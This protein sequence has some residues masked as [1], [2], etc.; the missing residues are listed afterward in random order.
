MPATNH[1]IERL[2]LTFRTETPTPRSLLPGGWWI[3]CLFGIAVGLGLWQVSRWLLAQ[4]F[5]EQLASATTRDEAMMAIES[6]ILLDPTSGKELV[7][8]LRNEDLQ[9]ARTSYRIIEGQITRWQALSATDCQSR[10]QMLLDELEQ[11]PT[12]TSR[13]HQLLAGSLASRVYAICLEKDDASNFSDMMDKASRIVER[14][15]ARNQNANFALANLA[16]PPGSTTASSGSFVNATPD[17]VGLPT[18]TTSADAFTESMGAVNSMQGPP[19]PLARSTSEAATSMPTLVSAHLS[20][21]PDDAQQSETPM[22]S[23]PQNEVQTVQSDSVPSSDRMSL[24]DTEE[25]DI[26]VPS[27]T[28]N[29]ATLR[30]VQTPV[31]R[32]AAMQTAIPQQLPSEDPPSLSMRSQPTLDRMIANDAFE[33]AQQAETLTAVEEPQA[34]QDRTVEPALVGMESLPVS[35]LVRLLGSVQA[36]VAQNAAL[37]L[38]QRGFSDDK[39]ELAMALATGSELQRLELVDQIARRSDLDPR[40]WLLWMAK[41]GQVAVRR[42]C[43]THLLTMSDRE[44]SQELQLLLNRERDP[45]ISQSIQRTLQR[46]Q[47]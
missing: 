46:S 30:L 8:G 43:V 9:I 21:N 16:T 11:L 33:D 6:L 14:I 44:V 41:D 40:V 10:M 42:R 37:T 28:E 7:S 12:S 2:N 34:Q 18:V 29:R 27:T 47:R 17:A 5:S 26:A 23:A 20:D 38:R 1:Q 22:A 32:I 24:N 15:G 19:P 13:Q 35:E 3:W 31:R 4:K 39:L 25:E 45:Q 36:E